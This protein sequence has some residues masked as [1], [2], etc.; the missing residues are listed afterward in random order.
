MKNTNVLIV[1]AIIFGTFTLTL[2]SQQ[3]EDYTWQNVPIGGGGYIT[4]MKI[5]PL[6]ASKRYYRTDVGGAYRWDPATERM[7]QMIFLENKNYYSVAG[8]ALHPTN[9]NILYLSVGLNCNTS[10]S[11]ILKSTDA[12]KN[13]SIVP[14]TQG[15]FHFAANGGRDCDTQMDMNG[16]NKGDKDRQG[17]PLAI[18]PLNTN[19]L[20][21]G[22]REGGLFILNLTNNQ[23]TQIPP[24]EIPHNNDQ[25]SIRSVVFHPT[26][27][28]VYIAYPGHGVYVG[29][30]DANPRTFTN[31]D[32]PGGPS[33]PQ[34][35]DAI[36]ISISKDADYMLVACK[37]SGIMKATDLTGTVL[38]S[39]LTGLNPPDDEGYLTADCSP[40][41]NDV[42]ITVVADWF[43]INQFQVTTDGGSTWTQIGGSV[44]QSTNLFKWRDTGFASHVS[45]IA[46]DPSTP[47]KMHYTSWFST[48]MCDNFTTAGPNVWHNQNSRGHEEIV[49]TD[50]AAFPTNI[51]GNFL[52]SGSGD[53]TGFLFDQDIENPDS[54]AAFG[55]GDRS[56]QPLGDLKKSASVDFC[57]MQPNH[58]VIS[59]TE[60]WNPSPCG[61]LKST[62]GGKEWDLLSGY[63]A[64]DEK[65]IVAMSSND[66]DNII[67]LN[68]G[69]LQYTKNGGSTAFLD[70]TGS[71]NVPQDCT[72]PFNVTCLAA[73]NVTGNSVNPSVFSG[74]RNITADRSI[75]CVFYFYDWN[76]DFSISTDGGENW[77]VVND[78]DLPTS[79]S[80]WNKTRLI[81]VPNHPG[82]LWINANENLYHSTNGGKDWTNYTATE[83]VNK[84]RALSFGLGFDPSYSA[85]YIYGTLDGVSDNLLYRSDDAGINWI[86]INDPIEKEQWGDPKFL[87]GDRNVVGRVYAGVSGQGV[88]Y[89]DSDIV[90]AC[91]NAEKTISGEFNTLNSPNIPDWVVSQIGGATMTGTTNNWTKA[92][93]DVSSPGNFNYDLQLWQ[94][95]L[96]MDANKT[97]LVQLDLRADDT[98][99][100]TI[101]LRNKA[102]G[103]IVYLDRDIEVLENAQEYAFLIHP[104]TSDNDLRLTLMIGGDNETVY[105]DHIRFREFCQGDA[106]TLD[107]IN[108]IEVRDVAQP[109]TYHAGNKVVSDAN[110]ISGQQVFFKSGESILLE[111]GFETQPGSVLTA[112]IEGCN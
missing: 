38:W 39:Q 3:S 84:V 42:A 34:H 58:L 101:K 8:I 49:P 112:E 1:L 83:S 63:N 88:I 5:H 90:M 104:T 62:D 40:H 7:E 68:T 51:E 87:A 37:T 14:G 54:F 24:S 45:Q 32:Y 36:D 108:L 67:A 21:I 4:G 107:C 73:T 86:Q 43:H 111:P 22:T 105:V 80:V 64:N 70:A 79:S 30:T 103:N 98:R 109:S 96:T 13:F 23:L 18:N 94:D 35:L 46:F 74:Y 93:L 28:L 106:P 44:P 89:G 85:L 2:S 75:A 61:I 48:F 56:N 41:D 29:D 91:D 66:P 52:M 33:Y 76:G 53:H 99:E 17:T 65:A 102:N 11:A 20:Y 6:D 57:E 97:Y 82:H 72:I 55:I 19:E 31:L 47:T 50:L 100:V 15:V 60:E 9:T 110:I 59:I 81:S 95:D 78:S 27:P 10:T 12:G 77:C 92:V 69:G 26:E 71:V 25:Y 16:A